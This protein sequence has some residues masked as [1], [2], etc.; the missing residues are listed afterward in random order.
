[1]TLI[2]SNVIMLPWIFCGIVLDTILSI[3]CF[4]ENKNPATVFNEAGEYQFDCSKVNGAAI[5]DLSECKRAAMKLGKNFRLTETNPEFPK[6]CYAFT[7]GIHNSN[8]YWNE[9]SVGRKNR[10]ASPICKNKVRQFSIFHC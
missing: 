7:A 10:R 9:H 3:W 1:M 6:G 8:V 4:P 2:L 5:S